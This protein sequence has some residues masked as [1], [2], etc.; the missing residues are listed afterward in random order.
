MKVYRFTSFTH[1]ALTTDQ[2]G[3]NLPAAQVGRWAFQTSLDI[4]EPASPRIRASSADVLA[5]IRQD[6]YFVWPAAFVP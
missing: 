1:V 6:G 2:T 5:A 3:A 4:H